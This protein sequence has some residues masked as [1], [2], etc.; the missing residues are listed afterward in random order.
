MANLAKLE[1]L[2]V[3]IFRI[4]YLSLM[5]DAQ[6]HLNATSLADIIVENNKSSS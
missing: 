3:D 2:V 5:L 4:N 1:F 6:I